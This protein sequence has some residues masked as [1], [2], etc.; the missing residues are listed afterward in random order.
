MTARLRPLVRRLKLRIVATACLGASVLAAPALA[1]PKAMPEVTVG[2]T[3][4]A[5]DRTVLDRISL[6]WQGAST[7]RVEI[8]RLTAV[9]GRRGDAYAYEAVEIAGAR[10]EGRNPDG[11]GVLLA[12]RIVLKDLVLPAAAL[13]RYRVADRS[14]RGLPPELVLMMAASAASVEMPALSLSSA[15]EKTVST[16]SGFAVADLVRGRF[17]KLA[18]AGLQVEERN[19]GAGQD[20][21]G[22]TVGPMEI[23]GFDVGAIA[24]WFDDDLALAAAGGK[25]TLYDTFKM[26]DIRVTTKG[27]PSG[28]QSL[29]SSDLKIGP[30]PIAPSK[31]LAE[32]ESYRDDP[33][34]DKDRREAALLLNFVDAFELGHLEL[35]EFFG[36]EDAQ[37]KT[38]L[39]LF[40]VE[41]LSPTR[42]G[43]MRIGDL[44]V[45]DQFDGTEMTLGSLAIRGIEIQ[46]AKT[47]LEAFRLTGSAGAFDPE[48]FPKFRLG[49]AALAD[50]FMLLPDKGTL[51]TRAATLDAADWIGF[52][53]TNIRAEIDGFGI[54]GI[55]VQEPKIA[56]M[57]SELG[58]K[59]LRM[60][61]RLE[62][63]WKAADET[64]SV[65]P[66][67][68][69]MEGIGSA[70]MSKTFGKVSRLMF[71][72]PRL[73]PMLG[74][75][76]DFRSAAMSLLD[77]GGF[78]LIARNAE[79]E[80]GLTRREMANKARREIETG[81]MR[82]ALPLATVQKLAEAAERFIM[83]PRSLDFRLTMAE[84][85]PLLTLGLL[86]DRRQDSGTTLQLFRDSARVEIEVNKAP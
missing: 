67:S 75:S 23:A 34:P 66:I 2:A 20:A 10:L 27:R 50:F 44:A 17:G 84:P 4:T 85:F 63:A 59:E 58:L 41:N 47:F 54:G 46:D 52:L 70:S 3:V 64:L 32:I 60:N 76:I 18:L 55:A 73:V 9:G 19:T 77:D 21:T 35:T 24:M 8:D 30:P 37:P 11:G 86:A 14:G 72:N 1:A 38:K 57:M 13:E 40:R 81:A 31:V 65:G 79:K 82:D 48:T 15:G 62:V 56:G 43:E 78:E 28:Y 16:L 42:L 53:P 5:G 7:V 49:G 69:G 51:H 45:K 25:K 71:E 61:A 22:M 36:P 68:F 83:Q 74:L 12:S 33:G 6:V 39:G 80:T 26:R 29:V